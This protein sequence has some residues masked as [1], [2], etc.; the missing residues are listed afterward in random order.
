MY[1]MHTVY[2]LAYNENKLV[3]KDVLVYQ[4][5]QISLQWRCISSQRIH[6]CLHWICISLWGIHY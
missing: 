2:I 6:I 1:H 4:W 5:I 3:Y